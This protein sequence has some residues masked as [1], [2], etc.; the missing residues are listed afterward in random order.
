M[1]VV[2]LPIEQVCASKGEYRHCA[3]SFCWWC[4]DRLSW[5]RRSAIQS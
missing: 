4:K 3:F 1:L 2:W 5:G